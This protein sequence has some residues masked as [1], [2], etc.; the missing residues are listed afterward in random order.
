MVRLV[1]GSNPVLTTRKKRNLLFGL[2]EQ[3]CYIYQVIRN[4]NKGYAKRRN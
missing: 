3:G 2:R 1:T 4:N